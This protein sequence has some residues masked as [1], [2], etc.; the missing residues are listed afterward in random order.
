MPNV[1]GIFYV[2]ALNPTNSEIMLNKS[3]VLGSLTPPGELV[4]NKTMSPDG[5]ELKKANIN[6]SLDNESTK[7]M[8]KLLDEICPYFPQYLRKDFETFQIIS[9]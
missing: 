4:V 5:V 6:K 2:S 9:N 1:N 3:T 8:E 7:R